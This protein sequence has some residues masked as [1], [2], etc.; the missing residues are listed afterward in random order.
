MSDIE[1]ARKAKKKHIKEIAAKLNLEEKDL[2]PYGHHIAKIDMNSIK[3]LPKKNS[4]LMEKILKI[5]FDAVNSPLK[6]N[7]DIFLKKLK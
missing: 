5:D 3:K 2:Q 4:K 6:G 1:I 7:F